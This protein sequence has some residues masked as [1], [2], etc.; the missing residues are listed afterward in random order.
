MGDSLII[1]NIM[2]GK[3]DPS[4]YVVNFKGFVGNAQNN[5]G[6]GRGYVIDTSKGVL[7]KRYSLDKKGSQYHVL[8]T[9]DGKGV[10]KLFIDTQS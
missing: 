3:V 10:G 2:A 6:E 8:T 9:L 5:S 7:M 1:E 4:W